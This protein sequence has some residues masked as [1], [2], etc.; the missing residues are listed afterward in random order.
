MLLGAAAVGGGYIF[1]KASQGQFDVEQLVQKNLKEV[2]A[3]KIALVQIFMN[4]HLILKLLSLR[5]DSQLLKFNHLLGYNG[6]ALS[7]A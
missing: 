2:K 6:F 4:F 3:M 5:M 7:F 1:Y